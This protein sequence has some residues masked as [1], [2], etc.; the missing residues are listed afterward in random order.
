VNKPFFTIII[1]TFNCEKTIIKS[2]SSILD[3]TFLSFEI[4]IIDNCSIDLT[5]PMLNENFKNDKRINILIEKDL[6][7]YYAMNK[8]IL[9]AKGEWL[10]FLGA[11]DFFIDNFILYKLFYF[12][13]KNRF[14]KI[15]Y[16]NVYSTRFNGIYDGQFD[17]NKLYLK[18]ICHQSIFYNK[19]IFK[20]I[21]LY[22]TKFKLYADYDLNIKWFLSKKINKIFYDL[23]ISNY[24]DGGFISYEKDF[25]FYELKD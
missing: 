22:D 14:F 24:A 13:N 25:I 19:S 2:I 7:I 18:N 1:P 10:Y 21:G 3:Q 4:L 17:V 5:I 9:N 20:I 12:I 8:G 11:D 6:G 23:L 16:V 15:I